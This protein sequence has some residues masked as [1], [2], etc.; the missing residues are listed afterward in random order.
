MRILILGIRSLGD[1]ALISSTIN[2]IKK[3]FPQTEIDFLG[4]SRYTEIFW[5]HPWVKNIYNVYRDETAKKQSFFKKTKNFFNL[6]KKLQQRNYDISIDLFSGPRSA[7]LSYLS[8]APLRVGEDKRKS[9]RGYLYNKRVKFPKKII[10]IVKQHLLLSQAALGNLNPMPTKLFLTEEEKN[11]A[12]KFFKHLSGLKIGIFPGSGWKNK[13][14]P[15]K[16]FAKLAE[17]LF[18]KYKAKIFI[19]GGKKDQRDIKEVISLTKAPIYKV[20][21]LRSLRQ[22]MALIKACDLFISNDTGP[23]HLAVALE[24]PIIALFGPQTPL[25]YGPWMPKKAVV[26]YKNLPCSPCPHHNK[27]CKD[28]KCMKAIRVEEVFSAAIKI[29]EDEFKSY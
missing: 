18:K 10:H 6:I 24:V 5:F 27:K 4:D 14:W 28:N 16:N 11:F 26:F 9:I 20:D 2:S 8:K 3:K 25:R 22:L 17:L 23:M 19:F 29:I 7:I 12:K 1:V 21:N 15:A 13:N